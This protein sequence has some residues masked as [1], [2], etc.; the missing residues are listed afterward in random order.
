M[1]DFELYNDEI[2]N[3]LV[4]VLVCVQLQVYIQHFIKQLLTLHIREG[5]WQVVLLFTD[6]TILI[7]F[8]T[9]SS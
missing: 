6:D 2:K 3:L 1:P 4:L 8:K 9:Q 7:C 5:A